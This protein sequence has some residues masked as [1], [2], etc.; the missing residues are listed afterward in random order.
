M[1]GESPRQP[2]EAPVSV[3]K[4]PIR[5]LRRTVLLVAGWMTLTLVLISVL[6]LVFF[7]R[8]LVED[9]TLRQLIPWI[10]IGMAAL[11]DV[12]A[13]FVFRLAL[14]QMFV[15]GARC[16]V[17]ADRLVWTAPP[18]APKTIRREDVTRVEELP[19]AEGLTLTMSGGSRTFRIP[20]DVERYE[21]L[22]DILMTWR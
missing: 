8:T 22:K 17:Y 15:R 4:L 19:A 1:T 11:A 10:I 6:V 16:E 7:P 21:E 12:G 3:H 14:Q 9:E 2:A 13:F 18:M 5:L 20:A